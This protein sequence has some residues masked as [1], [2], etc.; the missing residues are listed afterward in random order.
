MT[1]STVHYNGSASWENFKQILKTRFNI[2]FG[3]DPD[4]SWMEWRGHQVHLDRQIP[5]RY[6]MGTLV[7]VH[8]AGGNGRLLA[9]LGSIALERGWT[10]V[11]PDMPGYGM[12]V[13]REG[14]REDY[15]E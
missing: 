13:T 3:I 11:A 7:L 1:Q 4:E 10:V 12:T 6:P 9:P 8:G 15:S 2:P 14:W 5:A